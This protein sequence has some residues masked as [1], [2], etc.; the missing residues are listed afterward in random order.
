MQTVGTA[1]SRTVS[2]IKSRQSGQG[3][4]E[5]IIIVALIAIAA[6]GVYSYFGK[7]VRSQTAGMANELAGKSASTD[8]KNAQDAAKNAASE[9]TTDKTMGSYNNDVQK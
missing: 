4:T 3:M 9:S 6:I 1:I 7:T 5:Y 2:R 8:I